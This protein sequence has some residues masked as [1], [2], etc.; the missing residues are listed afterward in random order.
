[1]RRALFYAWVARCSIWRGPIG[2]YR[3]KIGAFFLSHACTLAVRDWVK[4]NP[5]DEY[6]KCGDRS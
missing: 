2:S 6:E 4:Y 3:W 5:E 1:M